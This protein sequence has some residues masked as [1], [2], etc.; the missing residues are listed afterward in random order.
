MGFSMNVCDT[1]E[2]KN[3]VI[4][5]VKPEKEEVKKLKVLSDNN[6]EAVMNLDM[7]SLEDRKLILKSIDEFGLDT[8]QKSSQKNALL[9]VS[10]K[11]LSKMGDEGGEVAIGLT[12]L[13]RAMK[14]L[15]PSMIDFTKK[16]FFGRVANPIR[17]YF[18]KYQ[19][20]DNVI[21]DIMESLEK[22]K[23][24]LKNDNTTLEIEE[25]SMRD[26]TKKLAKEIEMGIMM[27]EE[28]SDALNK[29]KVNN[30]D[31]DRISFVSEEILFPLRQRI[32]DMQQMI[33]VNQ[34][35]IIAIE[36]IRRNNK[37]LIR[38]VDRAKNVTISALR[39]ATIVASALYNQKIVLK[40]IDLLNKTTNDLISGTSKMLKEQG[41]EIQRQSIESNISVDTLKSAF[42]DTLEALNAIS[43]YKQE[44][45]PRLKETISQFK[46][47][48]D[49]GEKQISKLEKSE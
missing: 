25:L 14:D 32:M 10:I 36:V 49:L 28:I 11:N 13:Q 37:E 6:V 20:A 44:A 23:I 22:G 15:D 34:Q 17:T 4:E 46:E 18:D 42:S 45:L 35:G 21:N 5:A 43:S 33:V 30:D 39:T 47:L 8:M 41:A 16:G 9:E 12:E 24:T 7:D 3:E 19:K 26:L 29:A 40:K 31:P 1:E 38:G 48:A 2:I 27:D